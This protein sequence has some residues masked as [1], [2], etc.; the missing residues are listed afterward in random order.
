MKLITLVCAA[1][2]AIAPTIALAEEMPNMRCNFDLRLGHPA[3]RYSHDFTS[4][5]AK[6]LVRK[7]SDGKII[8]STIL[9]TKDGSVTTATNIP[10]TLIIE[11]EIGRTG[12]YH[13]VITISTIGVF[14]T[15]VSNRSDPYKVPAQGL[16]V[17][18]HMASDSFYSIYYRTLSYVHFPARS[19]QRTKHYIAADSFIVIEKDFGSI[20]ETNN[21]P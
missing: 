20:N 5:G 6:C 14:R 2:F 9:N 18:N 15:I 16:V 21:S 8:A 1:S 13:V 11:P 4:A 19:A 17:E 10:V 7:V 3:E 12:S